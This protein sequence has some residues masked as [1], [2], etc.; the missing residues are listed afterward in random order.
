VT[1]MTGDF[2]SRPIPIERFGM[3]YAS[4]QKSLAAAGLTI[5]VVRAD[6][7]LCGSSR[8]PAPFDLARQ[9]A[10]G[11]K[12]NTPPTFAIIVA[13]RMLRRLVEGGGLGAALARSR[14]RSA[15]L[16]S[17][18]DRSGFY[19]CAASPEARS[20][21]NICFRLPN[22]SLEDKFLREAEANG[23]LHLR[24][25]PRVGGLR[26]SL[27]DSTADDAVHAL[28]EFMRHFEARSG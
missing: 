21:V 20:L 24:G 2:L 8:V 13:A 6:L 16:Y 27:Y 1:D 28:I 9:A 11:S 12:V 3:V 7:L 17:T 22:A 25:H 10:A 15:R 18:I 19:T 26:A 14:E 5:I 4:A 23:L